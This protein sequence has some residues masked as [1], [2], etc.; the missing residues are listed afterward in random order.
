MAGEGQTSVT[1]SARAVF[2]PIRDELA[3]V[4]AAIRRALDGPDPHIVELATY[5][6]RG[7]GK[8]LRPAL[9]L[10]AARNFHYDRERLLPV[11]AAVELIHMATLVHDDIVDGAT[12]RRGLP[13]VNV[14]WG[15]GTAVLTGDFLFA[16]AF[17]LLAADGDNRVVRVMAEAVYEMSTGEIEQQAQL[18]DPTSGEEGYYRRIYKKTAHFISHCC[19]MGGLMGGATDRQVEALRRYG[20]GIGMG[21]QVIDDILDLT[22]N[23]EQLG[24]PRGTDLRSGVLTLPVL[25]A[26]DRDPQPWLLER[27]A[28]RRV[29]DATVE[30]VREW[31]EATGGIAYARRRAEE[32]VHGALE[33]LDELAGAPMEPYLRA[34]G[35]FVLER[36]N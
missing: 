18:F 32:F 28:A 10:L 22:G 31:V 23:P 3:G 29:D 26:L 19:L 4:E 11:A 1:V 34:L 16:R 20:Y 15:T 36:N 21:F 13:T 8:R 14:R 7:G 6:Q 33:A 12:E 24:K 17:S 2:E 27:L 25:F 30:R 5:L 9:L 35:R